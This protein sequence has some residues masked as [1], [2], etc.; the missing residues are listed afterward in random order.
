GIGQMLMKSILNELKDFPCIKL[1]ATPAGFPV[2]AKLGFA[3]EYSIYMMIRLPLNKLYQEYEKFNIK[4][5]QPEHL[6]PLADFDKAIFGVERQTVL[7]YLYTQ[8][9][10]TAL[11]LEKKDIIKGYIMGRPGTNYYQLGPLIAESTEAS[12]ALLSNALSALEGIPVVVDILTDK[13]DLIGWL[14]TQGFNPQRELIRMY[15]RKNLIQGNVRQQ[16][17]ISGPELG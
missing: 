5:A 12:I 8:S 4:A 16:F 7:Q 14:N 6:Q 9:P 2:Y 10:A 11:I 13:K 17:L 15:Y 1:D 3:K